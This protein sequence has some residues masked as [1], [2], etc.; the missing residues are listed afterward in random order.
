M[1]EFL[2]LLETVLYVFE[3]GQTPQ[4]FLVLV[5]LAFAR[6]LSFLMIVP[7]FGG[8]A[9]PGRVKVATA[10]A[11]VII[12]Y[13]TLAVGI[14][15]NQPLPF[16]PIGFVALLI[17]ESL[18][19][20]TLGFAVSLVFE[21]IQV[22]GRLIDLQRGATMGES[23]APQLQERVSELGQFK[24]QLAIVIFLAIG[25][26]HAFIGALF[27]SFEIIPVMKF[28]QLSMGW[29]PMLIF[30]VQMTG[31]VLSIG[32][33]LSAPAII[34][35]LLTDLFFGIINRVAPQINV[36]FLSMPVKMIVG[37]LVVM[38]SL[39]LYK[40]RY[41]YYFKESFKLFEDL[42]RAIGNSMS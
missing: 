20:F 12:L 34:A 37:L 27:R 31:Y 33:Q 16:G 21:A 19:G 38:I 11:F 17:K 10:A 5:G 3:V 9:V 22:A 18:V 40:D 39:P 14:P 36:F 29:T 24:L 2:S 1:E 35:L 28:P 26:H 25:A 30:I 4:L 41:I 42:I 32:V 7:F 8:S 23:L 13:P 6:L 15:N